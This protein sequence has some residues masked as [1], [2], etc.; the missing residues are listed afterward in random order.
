MAHMAEKKA[1]NISQVNATLVAFYRQPVAKIS[2]ELFLSFGLVIILVVVA[3]QPTL[4]TISRLNKEVQEKKE[5]TSKLSSKISALSTAVNLYNQYL[6]KIE[7]LNQ[8]LPSS[9]S[10][11]PTLKIIEKIATENDVVITSIAVRQVPEEANEL[12]TSA[13]ATLTSL[14]ISVTVMGQYQDMRQFVEALHQSRRTIQVLSAGFSLEET[15]G[16]RVLTGNFV[17]DAPY[18]GVAQ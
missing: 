10:L 3:I 2:L 18:Y 15:R 17:L 11:I 6:P 7:L 13:T 12:P 5:L 16:E 4:T 8:A 1:V 14:P 9:A